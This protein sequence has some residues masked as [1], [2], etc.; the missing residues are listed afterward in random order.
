MAQTIAIALQK[1]GVGKTTLSAILAYAFHQQGKRVLVVDLDGQCNV[2]QLITGAKDVYEFDELDLPNVYEAFLTEDAEGHVTQVVEGLDLL[3]GTEDISLLSKHFFVT[4]AKDKKDHRFTL[5][6]TLENVQDNYDYIILDCAPA[7]GEVMV[8]A[9]TAADGV[10]IPFE[11]SKFSLSALHAF[12]GTVASA[13]EHTNPSLKCYGV[14]RTMLDTRSKDNHHYVKEVVKFYDKLVFE[15]IIKRRAVVGRMST[16]GILKFEE[17]NEVMS[18]YEP[19][20]EELMERVQ[21]TAVR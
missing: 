20:I 17:M 15:T 9:L 6:R 13:Q 7:L 18:I 19:F 5:K 10:V 8:N 16:F 2:T 12:M 3:L 21:E 4:L 14:L 11:T 1:G